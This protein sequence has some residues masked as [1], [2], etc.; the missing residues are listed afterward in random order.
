MAFGTFIEVVWKRTRMA[1]KRPLPDTPPP[2]RERLAINQDQIEEAQ[3]IL[4]T[5][6]GA[7]D[8][9]VALSQDGDV[10]A[11]AGTDNPAVIERMIRLAGRVWNE[12]ATRVA[13]ELIRFEEE[14]IGDDDSPERVNL[15][16]YS[17]H[18]IGAVTLTIGWDL[19]TSLTQIR[20][21]I[22]D[23]RDQ[24]AASLY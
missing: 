1:K 10:I 18:I 13:R 17:A 11:H 6:A 23:I 2:L 5:L 21:E 8:L 19:S 7:L 15:M 22:A 20:A 3:H 4:D 14:T 16:L 9:P 12:G 24:L